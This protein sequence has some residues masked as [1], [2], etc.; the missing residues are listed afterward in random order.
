VKKDDE[1]VAV[2]SQRLR[3]VPVARQFVVLATWLK[4]AIFVDDLV[5]LTVR[6]KDDKGEYVEHEIRAVPK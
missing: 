1:I 2:G 4:S 6:R 3:D 5:V